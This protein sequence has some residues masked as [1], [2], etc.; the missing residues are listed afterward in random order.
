VVFTLASDQFDGICRGAW[1]PK[2]VRLYLYVKASTAH[3]GWRSGAGA[4]FACI[5]PLSNGVVMSNDE[6]R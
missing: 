1:R 5:K 6:V 2:Q 4:G 3:T